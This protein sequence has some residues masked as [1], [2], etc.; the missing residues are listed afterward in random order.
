MSGPLVLL[1]PHA[2]GGRATR[3][4]GP[5]EAALK[6][7]RARLAVADTI[8]AAEANLFA[9][10]RHSRVVVAGGD[11]SLQRLLPAL[12]AQD[13]EL[14]LLP[15]GTGND[16]ARAF[17]V[18]RMRWPDAL[19]FA[20]NAPARRIDAG[21]V[22]HGGT[23]TPFIS[24]LCAGFDAA[25]GERALRAPGWLRGMPRY[26]W[27]TLA[28][29]LALRSHRVRVTADGALVHEGAVLF[30]STL[31]TPSYGSGM[32]AAPAACIDDGRLD[33]L[34]AGRFG[35]L[36]T[37]CMMPLLLSG[38]HQRH[39]RVLAR[40]FEQVQIESDTPMPVAADG[41]PLPPSRKLQLSVM[42]GALAAVCNAPT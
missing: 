41:E 29:I 40:R 35:R 38:Q 28:E 19:G 27:A 21:A 10:P 25:V 14:A 7:T 22:E 42:P 39:P 26:L 5:L 37:L 2:A 20:L 1:N 4:I 18:H 13:H 33:L 36:G 15:C 34:L 32:P 24:S 31:N 9:L 12:L 6:G 17:G 8:A 23:R 11:G 3:L 16:T 30:A